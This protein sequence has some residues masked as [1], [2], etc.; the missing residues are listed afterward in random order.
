MNRPFSTGC[1]VRKQSILVL[2]GSV[3]LAGPVMAQD[4]G[5]ARLAPVIDR[6][7]PSA[8]VQAN[9]LEQRLAQLENKLGNQGL[10]DLMQRLETLQNEVQALR[11]QVEDMGNSMQ[12]MTQR[13]RDLF[14]DI[15]NRLRK[16]ETGVGAAAAAPVGPAATTPAVADS[17]LTGM[18]ERQLYQTAFNTMK[19][20]RYEQAITEF[21]TLLSR[22][23]NG[24]YA[25][26]AQ[27]WI[28]EANYVLRQYRVAEQEFRKVLDKY[29]GSVK[30]PD[31]MLKLGF[32]YYELGEYATAR[33][34]L[35]GVTSRHAGSAAARL[36]EA[37][38]Q[39]MSTEGR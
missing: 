26:N 15:D 31:A 7:V 39:K 33:Q 8:A 4:A 16:L 22:F 36:A 28:G 2:L 27:Y 13:Q 38:L 24:E 19:D 21:Q 25:G 30:V 35:E 5:A 1:C 18:D 34:M 10:V 32:T 20:G 11:G 29:P 23:P 9:N 14:L 37:R 3:T 6:S 12:S 17:A